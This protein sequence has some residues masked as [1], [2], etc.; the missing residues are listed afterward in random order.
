LLKPPRFLISASIALLTS[1]VSAEWIHDTVI[2]VETGFGTA[3]FLLRPALFGK[4]AKARPVIARNVW[5][6]CGGV[7]E[8]SR[9]SGFWA[10]SFETRNL[11]P[12]ARCFIRAIL[13]P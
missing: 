10:V 6:E 2:G 13:R 12:V 5:R 7:G 4:F 1:G 3:P 9:P 8:E 11:R